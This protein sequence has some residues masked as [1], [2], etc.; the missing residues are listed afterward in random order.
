MC[1]LLAVLV[2]D[3]EL[4]PFPEPLLALQVLGVDP[5]RVS[6]VLGDGMEMLI[7]CGRNKVKV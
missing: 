1:C 3:A 7:A 2:A 6:A 4:Q 5:Q